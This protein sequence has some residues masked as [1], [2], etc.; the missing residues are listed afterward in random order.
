MR[1][2]YSLFSLVALG[3]AAFVTPAMATSV[4]GTATFSGNATVNSG[5]VFFNDSG[6]NVSNPFVVGSPNTG[7][8]SGLT[9]G[10]IQNLVGP[11]MTGAVSIP[12]FV[13]FN[14]AKGTIHFDLTN[15]EPG[16]GTAA[17]CSSSAVGSICTPANSPFTLIQTAPN[18]VAITLTLD[19]KAW[20]GSS[21][22]SSLTTGAFTTQ[23][24]AIGKIPDILSTIVG[25]GN[26]NDTYSASFVATAAAP[27]PPG[28]PEPAS[29]LL[30]GVGLLGAGLV[31]RRKATKQ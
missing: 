25:G 9:S 24:V 18:A 2:T 27:P 22:P 1:L 10:T 14:V 15:I 19:G 26:V 28:V 5:G 3:T 29:M 8:F 7:D 11:A 16:V 23:D 6:A 21:V 20:I 17:A 31:A 13:V 12:D 30:M 4:S